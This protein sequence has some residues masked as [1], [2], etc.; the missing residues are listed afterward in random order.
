MTDSG[1]AT[2][3]P[4]DWVHEH[5]QEYVASGGEQGHEWRPGVPTLLLTTTGRKSGQ[6]RRT[7]LIY[8]RDGDAYLVVASNGGSAGHPAWYLNLS[9]DPAVTVQVKDEVFQAR[10]RTADPQERARLWPQLAKTWP[11]YDDY[12]R[13]TDRE[14]PVV[15]L[16]PVR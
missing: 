10:A 8:G 13:H 6:R 7:A 16:E 1:T 12:Q 9:A 5:I 15:V 4:T 3:S 11:A 14:I 2:D